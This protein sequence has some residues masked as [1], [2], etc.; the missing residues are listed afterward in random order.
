[1]YTKYDQWLNEANANTNRLI[2]NILENIEPVILELL[3]KYK[4]DYFKEF[5]EAPSKFALLSFRLGLIYDLLRSIEKYTSPTDELIESNVRLGIKR[6]FEVDLKISRNNVEYTLHTEAIR[7]GGYNIMRLHYRYITST[8]L[9]KTE[10]DVYSKKYAERVKR[11]SRVEKLQAQCDVFKGNINRLEEEYETNKS[12]TD[13][14]ILEFVLLDQRK[15]YLISF[16]VEGFIKRNYEK[17]PDT[18]KDPALPEYIAKDDTAKFE[19]KR[20]EIIKRVTDVFKVYRIEWVYKNLVGVKTQLSKTEAKLN[21][22][23]SS[24]SNILN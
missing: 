5:E 14:Q 19:K 13:E 18:M 11:L 16:E 23:L 1:M 4:E 21:N 22:E 24:I 8:N 17:L 7:A 6:N 3:E 2:E 9:P 10:Y 12:M 15:W 20:E